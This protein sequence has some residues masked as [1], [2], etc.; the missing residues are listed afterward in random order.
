ME[1]AW[2]V[3]K[4]STVEAERDLRGIVRGTTHKLASGADVVG[5]GR[6]EELT[7]GLPRVLAR[8]W[9]WSLRREP[10]ERT[11]EGTKAVVEKSI[12]GSGVVFSSAVELMRKDIPPV[13]WVVPG[14]L[15]EG[16]AL[17]AGKPKLGKSW[18]ALG[19]CV[20]VAAGGYALSTR[21]VAQGA[22]LYL[23]L[24]DN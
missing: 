19:L 4:G 16:V 10:Q 14:I 2:S 3:A 7:P 15:P 6:L 23:A 22:A 9:G 12:A 5:G 21:P 24:E 8:W 11:W 20:A 1:A 17:L 18:L 13:R